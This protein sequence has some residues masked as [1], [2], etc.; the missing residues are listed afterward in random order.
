MLGKMP[1]KIP[2]EYVN[3]S[4]KDVLNGTEI[5]FQSR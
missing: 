5:I 1:G 4:R 2:G 3:Q